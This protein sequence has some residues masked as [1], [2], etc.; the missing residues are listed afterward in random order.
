MKGKNLFNGFTKKNIRKAES[1]FFLLVI[2][3]NMLPV[4]S[5]RFFPT[6][7]GPVHLYNSNL[8]TNLLFGNNG[9]LA[10]FFTFNNEPVPNWTGHFL[11]SL[12]NL[13]LPAFLAEKMLLILY[14]TGLP[15]FF[16]RLIKTISPENYFLCYL[17]FPFTYSYLFFQGFYNFSLS[18]IFLLITLNYWIKHDGHLLS[19]KRISGLFLLLT[20]IYFSHIFIFELCLILITL[21]ILVN[22]ISRFINSS[23]SV[24][25]ALLA[26][27][28]KCC[29]IILSAFIP[30]VLSIRYLLSRPFE[31]KTFV[32]NTQ[33][34]A[35]LKNIR[36]YVT[37]DILA[38]QEEEIYT[39]IL[40]YFIVLVFLMAIYC[41]FFK[42]TFSG[43]IP[44]GKRCIDT[45]KSRLRISDFWLLSAM[46]ILFLYFILPD[47]F[48]SGSYISA[49]LEL[50]FYILLIIWL[51][52]QLLP[53]WFTLLSVIV[54]LF[55][56]FNLDKCY[57]A[58]AQKL[59]LTAIS[60]YNASGFITPNS[61]VLPINY[62]DDWYYCHLS[63]YLGIDKP[64]VILE[65][66]ECGKDYFPLKWNRNSM[67][68]IIAENVMPEQSC[69]K[70][71]LNIVKGAPGA[72][73]YIFELGRR[74][75]KLD[76]C[77]IALKEIM[78]RDYRLVYQSECCKLFENKLKLK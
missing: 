32:D 62:S 73:D 8:I 2:V 64:M 7:D 13:F 24:K 9:N 21:N 65:N 45:I 17:I 42:V 31:L 12:F 11:L 58:T 39:K 16:R 28:K 46:L 15:F 20:L 60:C 35:W 26:L 55:C 63:N 41:R 44:F 76:S 1:Y 71:W 25:E 10:H 43:K 36:P 23:E 29:V 50:I 40:F 3:F 30:M 19:M 49:R 33:L 5:V 67:P 14:L 4:L 37:L 66:Y 53:K 47:T 78:L 51:S 56:N 48:G 6:L 52:V 34:I 57:M 38:K 75:E 61:I 69:C 18:I 22:V 68:L 70:Y 59:N 72:I 27:L 54:V 77:D 74:N